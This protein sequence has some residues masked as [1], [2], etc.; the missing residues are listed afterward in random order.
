MREYSSINY[1]RIPMNPPQ[2]PKLKMQINTRGLLI[3]TYSVNKFKDGNNFNKIWI[4]LHQATTSLKLEIKTSQHHV[5]R[6]SR[7][8]RI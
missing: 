7:D 2:F 5:V 8:A 4:R 6:F 3:M 1:S